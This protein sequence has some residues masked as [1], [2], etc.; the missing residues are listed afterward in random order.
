MDWVSH[1][2]TSL[3]AEFRYAVLVKTYTVADVTSLAS[4][5]ERILRSN[6]WSLAQVFCALINNDTLIHTH[7][8]ID[9]ER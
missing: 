7:A 2:T 1:S 5:T 4:D 8:W 3:S 9:W 6:G